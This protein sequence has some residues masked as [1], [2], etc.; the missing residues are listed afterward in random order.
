MTTVKPHPDVR[1]REFVGCADTTYLL[2]N[3]PLIAGVLLD[4]A[5]PGST[6]A[7]LPAMRPLAG[8]LGIFQDRES[9]GK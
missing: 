7:S 9:E 1:G 6:P 5:H 2:G 8:H 4:A 3:R